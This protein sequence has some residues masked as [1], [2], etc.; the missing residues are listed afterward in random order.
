MTERRYLET[1]ELT[2]AQ[3][4][5]VLHARRIG[6]R[7]PR[8]ERASYRAQKAEALKDGGLLEEAAELEEAAAAPKS[9]AGHLQAIRR[10]H[11][12]QARAGRSPRAA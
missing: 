5:E 8:F 4:L 2:P 3:I 11:G 1:S 12:A 7:A 6:A 9:V 10:Q